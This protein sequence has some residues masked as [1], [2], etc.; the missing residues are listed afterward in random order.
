MR[1]ERRY[2]IGEISMATGIKAATLQSRRKRL[3]ILPDRGGVHVGA[4]EANDQAAISEEDQQAK[5]GSA[6]GAASERWSDLR[7]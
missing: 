5:R 6:P 7:A 1:E 4:G 2:T 3:N